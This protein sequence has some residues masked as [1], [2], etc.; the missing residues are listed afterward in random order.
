MIWTHI[1]DFLLKLITAVTTLL[2][3]TQVP[4]TEQQPAWIILS[5]LALV[6]LIYH[7]WIRTFATYLYCRRT[8]RMP[9]SIQQAGRLD[10]AF[11]PTFSSNLKWLPMTF[12]KDLD[13]NIK[14][15]TALDTYRQWQTEKKQENDRKLQQFKKAGKADQ[16]VTILFFLTC[17]Y[18][19]IASILNLPPASFITAAYCR[20]FE[21]DHYVPILNSFILIIPTTTLFIFIRRN[22]R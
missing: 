16:I 17:G 19:V 22:I 13:D 4:F 3:I 2:L 7:Y 11:T 8:L 12:I 10:N 5:I 20:I 14:Y 21:T 9:V 18:F 6:F 15:Q 1:Y